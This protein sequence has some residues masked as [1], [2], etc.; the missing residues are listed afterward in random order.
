MS[1]S[2]LTGIWIRSTS[3][4]YWRKIMEQL[5]ITWKKTKLQLNKT[6]KILEIEMTRRVAKESGQWS[7][8]FYP[9]DLI[10]T[11]ICQKSTQYLRVR[12]TLAR[13]IGSSPIFPLLK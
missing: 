9:L 13:H 6:N 5:T 3:L 7:F 2:K 10:N 8:N 11:T 1:T 12:V 4:D